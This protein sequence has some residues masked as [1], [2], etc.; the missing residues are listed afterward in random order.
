M[1]YNCVAHSLQ[2]PVKDGYGSDR[3]FNSNSTWQMI[4]T[5][6]PHPEQRWQETSG[7]IVLPHWLPA[8]Q[9]CAWMIFEALATAL[10]LIGPPLW[11]EHVQLLIAG[12]VVC[13]AL[14]ISLL[15]LG[16]GG[17]C[18]VKKFVVAS[19]DALLFFAMVECC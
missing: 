19:A 14:L 10:R 11:P 8:A 2:M 16:L 5:V 6:N 7:R 4:W 13:C 17:V 9:T 15:V 18:L 1:G 3:P 12:R